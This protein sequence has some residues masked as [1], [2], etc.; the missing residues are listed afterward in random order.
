MKSVTDSNFDEVVLQADKP[1][2]VDFYT[3]MCQ[4][5]K[6]MAPI[7]DRMDEELDTVDIVKFDAYE[8]STPDFYSIVSVPTLILFHKGKEIARREGSAPSA[9][10]EM[11]IE[12]SLD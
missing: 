1:I 2:V 7:L 5:C 4:P 9:V 3:T 11:W 12:L 6:M 8:G 10:L